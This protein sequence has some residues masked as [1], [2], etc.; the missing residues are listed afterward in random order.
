LIRLTFVF[1]REKF[2]CGEAG[3]L[4][5]FLLHSLLS[6]FLSQNFNFPF[7]VLAAFSF[8]KSFS[9]KKKRE[10]SSCEL[11]DIFEGKHDDDVE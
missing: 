5:Q 11:F 9:K 7:L 10:R 1:T 4:L 8:V 6:C 2:K 3:A